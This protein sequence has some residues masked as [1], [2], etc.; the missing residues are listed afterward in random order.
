MAESKVQDDT[1]DLTAAYTVKLPFQLFAVKEV[2]FY[3][4]IHTRVFTGMVNRAAGM[5]TDRTVYVAETGQVYHIDRECTY[6]RLSISQVRGNDVENLRNDGGA[7]YKPCE[8]CADHKIP[9][10]NA[11]VY[12]TNYGNRYHTVRTCSRM[13]RTIHEIKLSEAGKLPSCSKC[14]KKHNE[15]GS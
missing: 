3:Q 5:E 12:I 7:K 11:Q 15:Y 8:S 2:R 13:K 10:S 1:I 14:G 4:R 6:L 9:G